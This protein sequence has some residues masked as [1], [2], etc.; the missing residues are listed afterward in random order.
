MVRSPATRPYSARSKAAGIVAVGLL[1][2]L[3]LAASACKQ[4]TPAPMAVDASPPPAATDAAP[5]VLVPMD[6]DSGPAIDAAAPAVKHVGGTGLT[7]NQARAKQCCNALRAQAKS[8][9][10]SPEANMLTTIAAQ[11]DVVAM[12]IGPTAGGEAPEFAALRALLKGHNLPGVCS[13][14]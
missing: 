14:L 1:G 6:V 13:A 4:P 3:G 9:G 12:Q 7:I 5:A 10:A 8:L 11:C 2:L